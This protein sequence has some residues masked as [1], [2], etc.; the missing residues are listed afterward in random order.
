MSAPL[1]G[2][3]ETGGSWCVCA[4]GRGPRELVAMEKFPTEGP[5]ETLARVGAFFAAHPGAQG[6]GVGA[7]GPVEL[8]EASPRWGEVLAA[9]PKPGW[10]GARVGT[11]LRDTLGVPVV[12]DTDVNAAAV[13]EQRWGAGRGVP[14]LCYLTVGTGIGAGIVVGGA[15]VHGLLHPEAGHVR[16]P[17]DRARDPFPGACPFHG[18][19]WEGLASGAALAR[20]WN[21][22]PA[23]LPDDHPAWALEAEYIA[24][25]ILAIV[26]IASPHRV[27]AGGG[28]MDRGPLLG[29]VRA[30]LRE[31]L[32]G[33]LDRPQLDGDLTDY[34]VAPALGD[35]A[36]VLGAIA[37]ASDE[38]LRRG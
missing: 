18:D 15:P 33:Y 22:D 28:V 36:G 14:S 29:L 3:V 7:F 2:G 17:H 24:A 27:I 9:T 21:A 6:V 30:R 35:E 37:L 5:A 26:M 25:G 1:I 31:L 32:G 8:D 34:L 13:G 19:C 10:A 38:Q 23:Q 16:I 12:L 20:R 11:T 4:L